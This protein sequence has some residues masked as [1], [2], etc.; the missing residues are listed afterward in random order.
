MWLKALDIKSV[1]SFYGSG[2]ID[3][4]G[5]WGLVKS[6]FC[7]RHREDKVGTSDSIL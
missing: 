5:S 7:G 3:L 4:P 2:V 6:P 1:K